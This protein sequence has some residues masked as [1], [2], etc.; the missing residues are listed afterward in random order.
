MIFRRFKN[1][2]AMNAGGLTLIEVLVT[3]LILSIGL[4]GFAVLHLTSL[5]NSHSSYYASIASTI[6]LDLEE[7]LW[8][9]AAEKGSTGCVTEDDVG[10]IISALMV[11]WGSDN[12]E[13]GAM[14]IPGLKLTPGP[15]DTPAGENTWTEV[16]LTVTW[17]DARFE[18]N[19]AALIEQFDYQAR[20]LCYSPAT[21]ENPEEAV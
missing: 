11:L 15:V 1:G 7:R 3:L 10:G 17:A 20:V 6:A 5:K 18:E 4:V 21:E 2:S 9:R 14:I 12:K 8:L 19:D 13:V 16:P